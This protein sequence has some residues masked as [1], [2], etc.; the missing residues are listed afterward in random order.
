MLKYFDFYKRAK[1]DRWTRL[2]FGHFDNPPKQAQPFSQF[3]LKYSF[4]RNEISIRVYMD[5]KDFKYH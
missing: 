3:L 4:L 1:I 5:T 2:C